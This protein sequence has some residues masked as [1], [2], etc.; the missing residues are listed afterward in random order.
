MCIWIH[1]FVIAT[2]EP[3]NRREWQSSGAA[4]TRVD[5]IA[6]LTPDYVERVSRYDGVVLDPG[7][8]E[9]ER[10]S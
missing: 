5:A 7:F 1:Q 10:A 2:N 4:S 8:A 9:H 3:I 6:Q